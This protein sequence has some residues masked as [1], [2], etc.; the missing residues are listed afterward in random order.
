MSTQENNPIADLLRRFAQEKGYGPLTPEQAQSEYDASE[1]VNL[2]PD[3][4]ARIAKS[5]ASGKKP[6]KPQIVP[7]FTS[8]S[9]DPVVNEALAVLNRNRGDLD[10]ETKQQLEKLRREALEDEDGDDNEEKV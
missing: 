6:S 7:S 1:P 5:V 2:S 4:I 8:E 9:E 3:L 10:P